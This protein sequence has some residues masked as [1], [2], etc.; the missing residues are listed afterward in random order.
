MLECDLCKDNLNFDHA[1][2]VCANFLNDDGKIK[3]L[4]NICVCPSCW[5]E[6][7][8]TIES[9]EVKPNEG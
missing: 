2:Y 4:K 1:V 5:A 9:L 3:S 6:I 8:L 7:R